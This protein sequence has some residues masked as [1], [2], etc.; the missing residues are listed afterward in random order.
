[1]SDQLERLLLPCL[2]LIVVASLTISAATFDVFC[3]SRAFLVLDRRESLSSDA[4][5]KQATE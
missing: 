5:T 4:L 3:L 1:M 2:G